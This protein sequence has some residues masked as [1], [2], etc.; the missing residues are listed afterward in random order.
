MDGQPVVL[1]AKKGRL[2]F[3]VDGEED[4]KT[5]EVV[6]NLNEEGHG[7]DKEREEET[8][9]KLRS[10]G[11]M[12]CGSVCMDGEAQAGGDMPGAVDP[13]DGAF[14]VAEAGDGGNAPGAGAEG[15]P[16][17]RTG[18][19]SPRLQ[20]MLE[21]KRLQILTS[22]V[23]GRLEKTLSKVQEARKAETSKDQKPS[24][25]TLRKSEKP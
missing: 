6:Y 25:K 17:E 19:F 4:D 2:R 24:G 10:D 20:V 1:W 15:E 13:L 12:P 5:Q 3:S 14:T 16:G 22:T 21:K 11:E 9:D 8:D 23:Q 7:E 18:A